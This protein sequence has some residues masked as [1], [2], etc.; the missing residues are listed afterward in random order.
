MVKNWT[1]VWDAIRSTPGA[2]PPH[3][4]VRMGRDDDGTAVLVRDWLTLAREGSLG[5]RLVSIPI[6]KMEECDQ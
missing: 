6:W 5:G 4:Y 2:S 3:F 1:S